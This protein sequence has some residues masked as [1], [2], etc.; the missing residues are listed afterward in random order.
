VI[1]RRALLAG[2]A[3][4][5]ALPRAA[6]TATHMLTAADVH[7]LGYPTVEAMRWIGE[8]L[9]RETDGAL[10]VRV[11]HAGQLGRETDTLDMTRYGGLDFTRVNMAVLNNPF[12]A[13]RALVL[14][15]VF[16]STAHMRRALD[17]AVGAEILAAFE[18][19]DLIG[20]AF[21]DSGS[22]CFYN[23]RRPIVVPADL[24]GLKLRVPPSDIFMNLV[25]TLGA[26]P[27]PIAYGEVFSALQTGLI[28]GAE[29]NWLSFLTSRQFEV[30]RHW[31][32]TE[33]SSSPEALLM[34]RRSYDKLTAAQQALL[35]DV[36]QRSVAYMR[37]LW[38]TAE[39]GAREKVIAAGVAVHTI[40]RPAFQAA[41]MPLVE[42]E[43]RDPLV[44]RLYRAIRDLA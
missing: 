19:R 24:R 18:K 26:N 15:Y 13:T 8:T 7:V 25:R 42:R 28:D 27:T 35:R 43:R 20:L 4:I 6:R 11:Y 12:P 21:Y 14:P 32:Q 38:D 10:G 5:A 23:T 36:A 31:S 39:A 33:H 34:S 16:D 9:G 44:D 37:D 2:A 40:D 3:A 22:R 17:G 30:A 29:N 1:T 41:A